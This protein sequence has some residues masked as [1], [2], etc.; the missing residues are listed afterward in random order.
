MPFSEPAG[1]KGHSSTSFTYGL[2]NLTD[3][4]LFD[5]A[6]DA[7]MDALD[8]G[9]IEVPPCDLVWSTSCTVVTTAEVNVEP[10]HISY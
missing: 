10:L 4:T 5:V 9:K 3:G 1:I 7:S 2:P 8:D 6:V